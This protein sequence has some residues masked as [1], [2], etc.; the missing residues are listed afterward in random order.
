MQVL[1]GGVAAETGEGRG[2]GVHEGL[3]HRRDRQHAVGHA[4]GARLG[5]GVFQADLRGVAVRHHHRLHL[6]GAEGVHGDGQGQRRIDAAGEAEHHALEAVLAHIVAH[7]EH[8]RAV[9]AGLLAGQRRA[10]AGLRLHP[11]GVDLQLGE[12]Q[13]FLEGRGALQHMAVGGHHA[14]AAVEHQLVLTADLVDVDDRH[15]ALGGARRQGRLALGLL[16]E[17]ER[18]GVEV[19]HQ[20]RTGRARRGHRLGVPDVLADA[21]RHRHPGD[22]HHAGRVAGVEVALLVEHLVVGQLA[23]EV[24]HPQRAVLDQPAGVIA[25]PSSSTHGKPSTRR[26]PRTSPA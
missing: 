9:H 22:I 26:M 17:V 18:R 23:L 1:L 24:A 25:S 3:D 10:G 8:Q 2:Q 21:Q 16:A 11:L 13:A 7:P 6:P 14:G 12:E 15:A 19:E 20:P 5:L 4:Q